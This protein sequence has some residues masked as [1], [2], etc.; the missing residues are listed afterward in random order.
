[1]THP[2]LL[3]IH[4][5]FKKLPVLTHD[6]TCRGKTYIVTGANVGLGL[7]TAR[8]LV[9]SSAAKVILAVRNIEAGKKAKADIE[10]TTGR[11]GVV[12]VWQLDLA[13][14]E[15]MKAFAQRSSTLE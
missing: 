7:E 8:H 9:K 3:V 2:L 14:V 4:E 12:E 5:Q 13:S 15:S 1:M 11:S 6:A 10:H